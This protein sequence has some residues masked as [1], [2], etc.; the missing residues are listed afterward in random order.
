M[1]TELRKE[2]CP[3]HLRFSEEIEKGHGRIERR[4][5]WITEKTDWL[6]MKAQWKGLRSIGCVKRTR[7]LDAK[8]SE[9]WSYF[10]A[11]IPAKAEVFSKAVRS[12]WGI[13]NRLHWALDV[14][15]NEDQSR[16]RSKNTAENMAIIRHF[17]MNL[18]QQAKSFHKGSMKQLRKKAGWSTKT[19]ETLL[20]LT[21]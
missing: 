11:S 18:L 16:L 1:Q 5:Y 15:F 12:H 3:K 17:V 13:E 9:E 2:K 7:D 21:F 4:E 6:E 14:I 20:E 19:L 10:I 8:V